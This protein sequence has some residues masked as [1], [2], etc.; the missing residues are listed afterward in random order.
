MRKE[1][2]INLAI[3]LN[4]LEDL[5]NKKE[6]LFFLKKEYNRLSKIDDLTYADKCLTDKFNE[7]YLLLAKKVPALSR[8]SL[9]DKQLL[10]NEA[11]DLL[12]KEGNEKHLLK[13][14][15]NL[16]N[17]FRALPKCQKEVDDALFEEFKSIRVDAKKKV[18][19]Y[20]ESMKASLEEKKAKKLEIIESAKKLLES[21]NMKDAINSMDKLMDN[22]KAI[23][24]AGNE[25]E[26]LWEKF[27]EVRKEFSIKR[28]EYYENMKVVIDERALKKEE[29]IKKVK[30][31]T[32]EAYFTPEEI[33]EIKDIDKE[34][35]H[36]GFA[37]KEKDQL[38]WD[39]MQAAIK[40]YFDEMKFYK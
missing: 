9:E 8:S 35:R 5:S 38:L 33:K 27:H 24:F 23:G 6:D 37:G 31:I 39:E 4:N 30:Y 2:L 19:A 20:Y 40:K 1:E 26:T 7:L 34:F 3:E 18:D 14:I 11:K 21:S 15:N 16:F 28:K 22:W 25:D 32:S 13:D 29:L 10:I 12:S 36:L 17:D